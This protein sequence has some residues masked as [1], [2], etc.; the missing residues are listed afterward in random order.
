MRLALANAGRAGVGAP[1]RF[2]D[3]A[4]MGSFADA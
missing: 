1:R 4:T 3:A 2:A